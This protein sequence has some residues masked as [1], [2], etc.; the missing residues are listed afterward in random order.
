MRGGTPVFLLFIVAF[1]VLID[2]YSFR[3]IKILSANLD[4]WLRISIYV[5]FWSIPIII[6]ITMGVLSVNMRETITT[7]KY[8]QLQERI[9]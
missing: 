8:R 2:L 9:I 3:G 6:M 7:E 5:L 4:N 1:I